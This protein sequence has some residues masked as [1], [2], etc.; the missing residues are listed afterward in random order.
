MRLFTSDGD[1]GGAVDLGD[2]AHVAEAFFTGGLRLEVVLD[3]I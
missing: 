1:S 3:A 2:A